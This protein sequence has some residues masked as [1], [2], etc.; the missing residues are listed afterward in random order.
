MSNRLDHQVY[1]LACA[2]HIKGPRT[3]PNEDQKPVRKEVSVIT[4]LC[5]FISHHY[6]SRW[7]YGNPSEFHTMRNV[8]PGGGCHTTSEKDIKKSM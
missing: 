7:C 8:F 2:E 3:G 6:P 1:I 5:R 4:K